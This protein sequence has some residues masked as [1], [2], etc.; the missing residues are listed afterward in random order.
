M[1]FSQGSYGQCPANRVMLRVNDFWQWR[2][3]NSVIEGCP[4]T[5]HESIQKT[6]VI[7]RFF[8][9]FAD[10]QPETFLG[11]NRPRRNDIFVE[12]QI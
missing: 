1:I 7:E 2:T 6:L 3:V 9:N 5:F 12:F 10:R 8:S 11:K 4:E